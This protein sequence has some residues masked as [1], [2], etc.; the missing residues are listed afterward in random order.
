MIVATFIMRVCNKHHPSTASPYQRMI[1]SY[2][3][4]GS[5]DR[6]ATEVQSSTRVVATDAA[7]VDANTRRELLEMVDCIE[8]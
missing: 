1:S 5:S 6:D 8:H 3:S 4:G 2:R 7:G